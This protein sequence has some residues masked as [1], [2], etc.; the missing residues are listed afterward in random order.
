MSVASAKR[1][2]Y[3][4]L[5]VSRNAKVEEIKKA[6]RRHAH[7]YHPD[8]NE[9]PE[10]EA[11]FKEGAEAFEVLSDPEKRRRYDQFGH[12]GLSGAGV[13]DFSTMDVGDIFSMFDGIFGGAF[14]GRRRSH[15]GGVDLQTEITLSLAEVA[16]GTERTIE[17]ARR[18]LC[19]TCGGSGAAPGS[20]RRA[21]ATCG[22]YGQVEQTTGLGSIFGRVITTCPACHGRGST[23]VSPCSACRGSGRV[24]KNR[25][26]SAKIPTGI[27]DGQAVRIR[28]EGEVGEEGDH[29][30]DLHCY[31]RVAP[32]PFLERHDNDLVCAMPVSFTQAALGAV[33]EV[34]TLSGKAELKIPSGT[35]YGQ[36]FRLRGLG[37]PDLRTGRKG[38]EIVQVLIE[39]PKHLDKDQDRLL[40]EFAKTE[41]RAVLPESKG[42]FDKL[43]EYLGGFKN[44]G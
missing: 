34:P 6:Y 15:P 36:T 41:D 28:G 2:Y 35:Q 11:I 27:H 25:V 22:G 4:T 20:Q 9:S 26:V 40:R 39:I 19:D 30:G 43:R 31:V 10:A 7:K 23:V 32:H 29:R 3:E 17:F 1:D 37:L 5:G 38:D 44:G 21:C 14:G 16:S 13:H 8:R 12:A 42:F 18:D 24:V 33:V